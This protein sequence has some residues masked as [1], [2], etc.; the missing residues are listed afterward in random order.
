MTASLPL[1]DQKTLDGPVGEEALR[2]IRND[3][4]SC[5][6]C[7]LHKTRTNV[8]FGEGNASAPLIM[9]VGEGP[10]EMEDLSGKPFIGRSGQLLTQMIESMGL[11]REE[12][13][14]GN[15]IKCRPPEN[16]IPEEDEIRACLGYLAAQVRA[17]RPKTIV[18]LGA[19]ATQ[20]LLKQKKMISA[21]RGS[22]FEFQGVPLRATYHP[23]YLLRAGN[24]AKKEARIDLQTVLTRLKEQGLIKELP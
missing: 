20:A 6:R 11:K 14:I 21:L 17:V 9:F 13:Y 12:V 8:V 19:T 23:S 7:R 10:G 22:W 24:E 5:I 3:V 1:F 4:E 2:P 16:R 18:T 15:V